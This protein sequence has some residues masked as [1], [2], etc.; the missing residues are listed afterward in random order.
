MEGLE[1]WH[2]GGGGMASLDSKLMLSRTMQTCMVMKQRQTC[3][4][5]CSKT[6][7]STYC[8]TSQSKKCRNKGEDSN[9]VV[10]WFHNL[11]K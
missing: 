7:C 2:R 11:V 3:E 10:W 5:S 8:L 6:P 4:S 1:L 9:D